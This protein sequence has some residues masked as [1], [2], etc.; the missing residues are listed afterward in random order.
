M[1][2]A[3]R[4]KN[5]LLV[6]AVILT[7]VLAV[8]SMALAADSVDASGKEASVSESADATKPIW[9]FTG[10]ELSS[11]SV[12]SGEAVTVTPQVTGDLGG[13]TY[14]YVWSYGGGWDL[15]G[16]TVRDTGRG[17]NEAT[18]TLALT[19]PGTYTV[20]VDVTDRSG[21]TR[22]MS[23]TLEVTPPSWSFTG[24]GLSTSSVTSGEP[25]TVTPQVTGDLEGAEYNYVWQRNGS[26]AKGEWGS[27]VLSTGSGTPDS[28]AT[29]ASEV[30]R[31]GSYTV[32]V[33]VTDRSGRTRT[34]SAT[35]EVTPPSWS[36][37]GVELSASRVTSGEA[38]T[39]TPVTSGDLDGATYNYV[40]Q[41]NGSWA[42][43]EWGSTV[44]SG[45]SGTPDT[46]AT[47]AS[48][49]SRPGS[50]TVYVDVTDR[51]G[52]KRTMSAQLEVASPEWEFSGV[53]VSSS[54]VRVDE[55]VTVTPQ[56]SGDL[57]G[58]SYNYV[59]SY[60]GG[61]DLWGST[62]RDTG[63]GTSEASSELSFYRPG[64]YVLYVDVTDRSGRTRTMSAGVEAYDDSWSLDG[65]SAAPAE[66]VAGDEV[67]CAPR[68]SGDASGL[69]Y[70]YVW[71]RNGS[72]AEGDWG[73]T[74]LGEGSDTDEASHTGALGSP[75]R[76]T[77][78]VDAVSARGERRTASTRV[79]AWGVT[80]VSASGSAASGWTASADLFEGRGVPGTLYRFRWASSDG[81]ASG[82]LQDWSS[83]ASVSFSR[84]TL[85]SSAT[86]YE[87]YLDVKYPNGTQPSFSAEVH[88]S[89]WFTSAGSWHYAYDSGAEAIGWA[90]IN[91]SWYYFNG[92]G[93]MQT[94][95]LN[96][97]GKSYYLDPS[98]GK[99]A[100][101][102]AAGSYFDPDGAWLCYS[103]E[104]SSAVNLAR[105]VGSST[106]YLLLIDNS[107]CTT[108]VFKWVNGDWCAIYKWVCSPGKASTPTVRGTYYIGS[109]GYSFGQGFTC[110][111][112]TQFYG[113]YLFHSVLYY[114]GS[115]TVMDGTL[116]VPASHGCVRLDINNAYWIN[117]NI[118]SGTRVYS[119]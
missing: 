69:R 119:Y 100:T 62:V 83:T 93:A 32:Y 50:Y 106:N 96:W 26:W 22:T 54:R 92:S 6:F 37:S 71:Q 81:S 49:V 59:W 90:S 110:Y 99:M 17:T 3:A 115:R 58:A 38:V 16:S 51:S 108:W 56:V 61:W 104:A 18:G 29:L 11:S 117:Q 10:V 39:V 13:A 75:G 91:G 116:G 24:V 82:T 43:G 101:G 94:G 44:L 76:Y 77:L 89:G 78:Y 1:R 27:T 88:K 19:K 105:S 12:T 20:Y 53:R 7:C 5:A 65:V 112:W 40:W 36:F 2:S 95:W 31:A 97:G 86:A 72:W 64:R 111:Y 118:P 103:W 33:D 46:S 68:V 109:R 67:T 14:N 15:W 23:A 35:L 79:V 63:K 107:N 70:N 74:E 66:V 47:L 73:S 42:E 30:S 113:N 98:T 28:S 57:G 34:M 21:Q 85:N 25:V 48:E 52:E 45:G 84:D 114:E 80:G 60:E 4:C 87:I 102:F 8:P 41:R 9:E 55:P